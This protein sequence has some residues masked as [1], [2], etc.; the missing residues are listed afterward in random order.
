[1]SA[2]RLEELKRER[3]NMISI[4]NET[5]RKLSGAKTDDEKKKYREAIHGCD[6]EISRMER[7]ID[8]LEREVRKG[9]L[10]YL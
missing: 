1:M 9:G 5:N 3:G 8:K 6:S 2:K 7:E 4:R 10:S